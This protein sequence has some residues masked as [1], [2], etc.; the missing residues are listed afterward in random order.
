MCLVSALSFVSA[1]NKTR[2]RFTMISNKIIRF[3]VKRKS[4]SLYGV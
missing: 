3:N 2:K 4:G 1:V